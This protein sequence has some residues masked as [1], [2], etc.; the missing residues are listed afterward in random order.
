[1]S[2]KDREF[3]DFMSKYSRTSQ[4]MGKWTVEWIDSG[5]SSEKALVLLHGTVG[6]PEVFWPQ[7]LALGEK[8]RV[9]SLE[10]PPTTNVS[11][12]SSI[13]YEV[14]KSI[15]VEECI[16]TGTSYGGYMAQWFA[17]AHEEMVIGLVLGNTF[18]DNKFLI[19]QHPRIGRILPL[20]PSFAV[21]RVVTKG[22]QRD[23][24]TFKDRSEFVA[25]MK[26]QLQHLAAK[27][28]KSRLIVV[29]KSVDHPPTPKFDLPTLI[30][31]TEEDPLIPKEA[32]EELKRAY[33]RAKI[34]TFPKNAGHFP[35]LTWPDRYTSILD[36]FLSSLL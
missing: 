20:L 23:L 18:H 27:K 13:F 6:S 21:K 7:I 5:V 25:Y 30:I 14:L 3:V 16:F 1:M 4:K 32:Q 36:S 29:L 31:L 11:R 28:V 9:I 15:G 33:S 34:E 26:W 8:Y 35:Y 19:D 12:L 17:Q 10:A 24:E 2:K 22:I